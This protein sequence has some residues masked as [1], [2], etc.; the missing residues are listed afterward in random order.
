MKE[1]FEEIIGYAAPRATI[2]A[3][4]VHAGIALRETDTEVVDLPSDMTKRGL[5]GHYCWQQGWV[6]MTDARGCLEFKPR[7]DAAWTDENPVRPFLAYWERYYKH[8]RVQ[9]ASE[10]VCGLCYKFQVGDLLGIIIIF[11]LTPFEL[12]PC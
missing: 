2:A 3:V 8:V 10:D 12:L 7:Q 5:Y 6:V 11:V 9:K 4:K 1:Y